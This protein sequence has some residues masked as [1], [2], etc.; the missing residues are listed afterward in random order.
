MQNELRIPAG[1]ICSQAGVAIYEKNN[2][3]K[4]VYSHP[5][6]GYPEW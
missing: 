3:R 1:L 2:L 5:G 4:V 6:H